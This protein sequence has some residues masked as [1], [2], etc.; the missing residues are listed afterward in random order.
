[1]WKK[2]RTTVKRTMMS[3][4]FAS[5]HRM[6]PPLRRVT[7]DDGLLPPSPPDDVLPLTTAADREDGHDSVFSLLQ[8]V[9]PNMISATS[10]Y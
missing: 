3:S 5:L 9:A 10:V 6:A 4:P 8:L 2:S 1:M 7:D